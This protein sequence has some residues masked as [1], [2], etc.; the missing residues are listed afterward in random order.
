MYQVDYQIETVGEALSSQGS[1]ELALILKECAEESPQLKE[2]ILESNDSAGSEDATYFMERVKQ[3]G[4]LAAYC[5]F[6]TDLSAGHH[7]EQ[8]DI[9]EDTMLAAV[10]V[11]Y[12]SVVKIS[13]K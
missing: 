9:N 8:F 2:T 3:N 10:D 13:G 6:G 4:G 7:N 5:I 11:L 1:T 12:R